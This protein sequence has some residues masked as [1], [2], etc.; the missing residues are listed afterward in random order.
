MLETFIY[1]Q[2]TDFEKIQIS[3]RPASPIRQKEKEYLAVFQKFFLLINIF[4][5]GFFGEGS[6]YGSRGIHG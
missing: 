1:T 3:I 2:E 6:L 4:I 5:L